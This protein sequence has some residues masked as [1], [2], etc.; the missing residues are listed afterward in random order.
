MCDSESLFTILI[1]KQIEVRDRKIFELEERIDK[2]EQYSRRNMIRISGLPETNPPTNPPDSTS[3]ATN[4]DSRLTDTRQDDD[5]INQVRNL[6]K[7][8]LHIDLQPWE[9][10]GCHRLGGSKATNPEPQL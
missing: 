6:I 7:S 3:R 10:L 9:I 8:D 4:S 2:M 5:T 1:A